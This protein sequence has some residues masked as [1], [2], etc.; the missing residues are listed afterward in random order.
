PSASAISPIALPQPPRIRRLQTPPR[1]TA[2]PSKAMSHV[3]SQSNKGVARIELVIPIP[4]AVVRKEA[5]PAGLHGRPIGAAGGMVAC[6]AVDPLGL[7]LLLVMR[8][9]AAAIN[10]AVGSGS[11]LALPVLMALGIPPGVAVRTNTVVVFFSTVGFVL[12]Y[13]RELAA[14]REHLDL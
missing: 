11:L 12:G 6:A 1:T 14:E 13:P 5:P 3:A 9:V 4:H 10:A 8:A 7:V 2:T